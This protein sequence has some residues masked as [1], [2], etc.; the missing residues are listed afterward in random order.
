MLSLQNTTQQPALESLT[1]HAT[2]QKLFDASWNRAEK[3]DKNDTRAIGLLLYQLLMGR[4]AGTFMVEP[5]ADGRL[6]FLR[7]VPPELC[8]TV[9]RAVMR[10]HPQHFNT[11][12]ALF[13]ELNALTEVLETA[14]PGP[15][16]SRADTRSPTPLN[17]SPAPTDVDGVFHVGRCE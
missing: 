8:E 16:T 12:E 6:R 2:R 5:P 4:P 1:S 3:G 17:T 7:T 15:I 10:Q 13:A 11:V 14:T 9:A